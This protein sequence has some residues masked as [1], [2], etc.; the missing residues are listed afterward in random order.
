MKSDRR[1]EITEDF[2]LFRFSPLP[3]LSLKCIYRYNKMSDVATLRGIE[4]S[5]RASHLKLESPANSRI[6]PGAEGQ[7]PDK[8]LRISGHGPNY[9][10]LKKKIHTKQQERKKQQKSQPKN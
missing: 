6:E 10:I 2:H 9:A 7:R 3:P 4:R 8:V 1:Q 5:G